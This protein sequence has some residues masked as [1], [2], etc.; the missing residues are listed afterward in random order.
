MHAGI[1][2]LPMTLLVVVSAPLAGKVTDLIG[3]RWPITV[4]ML[5][6]AVA[7]L[8]LLHARHARR[9]SSTCSP[10]C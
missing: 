8:E 5:L 10:A 2:F 3:P 6:L 9:A 1:V 7:L 4:G